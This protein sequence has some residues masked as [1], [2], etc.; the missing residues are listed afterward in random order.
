MGC[1]HAPKQYL[2]AGGDVSKDP[3][4]PL[5]ML[6]QILPQIEVLCPDNFCSFL[7]VCCLDGDLA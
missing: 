4:L 7:T 2:V 6:D 1:S 3:G 5:Q